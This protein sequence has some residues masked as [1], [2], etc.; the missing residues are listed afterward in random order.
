[1]NPRHQTFEESHET[2]I[3][4]TNLATKSKRCVQHEYEVREGAGGTMFT[5][6]IDCGKVE[7]IKKK[8]K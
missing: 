4:Y 2:L 3:P 7:G 8:R 5:Q 1:M 6:C